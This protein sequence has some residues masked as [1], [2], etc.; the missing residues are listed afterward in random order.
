[1]VPFIYQIFFPSDYGLWQCNHAKIIRIWQKN[2][3]IK[4]RKINRRHK[5]FDEAV[6]GKSDQSGIPSTC[7]LCT[8][9]CLRN[10]SWFHLQEVDKMK[11]PFLIFNAFIKDI[12][13]GIQCFHG[14]MQ[15]ILAEGRTLFEELFEKFLCRLWQFSTR[16]WVCR[17]HILLFHPDVLLLNSGVQVP[18][19]TAGFIWKYSVSEISGGQTQAIPQ[20][21]TKF[22]L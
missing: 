16:F 9:Y 14:C 5:D 18:N 8:R 6:I 17:S 13:P 7:I 2:K 20:R 12:I 15:K 4:L 22:N 1:M 11:P 10:Q 21:N 3:T 19:S